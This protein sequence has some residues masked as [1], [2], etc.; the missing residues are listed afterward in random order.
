[1]A[2]Q[3]IE[4]ILFRQLASCLAMPILLVDPAGTL[5]Y[6]NEPAEVLLGQRFEET[7]AMPVNEWAK[8]FHPTDR[9]GAPLA[10]GRL[11][12]V[13]ALTRHRAEHSELWIQGMDGVRRH[14]SVTSLP[15]DGQA[16][17]RLGAVALFWEN[18]E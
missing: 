16:G 8:S 14:L 7:G 10:G 13:R 6:Y 12:L 11:P 2:Q 9:D 1:M 18:E 4:V 17:R 3:E 15:L 5:I